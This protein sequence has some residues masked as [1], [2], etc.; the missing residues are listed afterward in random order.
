MSHYCHECQRPVTSC[1]CFEDDDDLECTMCGGEGIQ[2]NDDPLW[3][4]FDR[5]WVNCCA[6]GGSGKRNHQSIF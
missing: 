6:C 2:D 5:D 1:E 3:H 4:G